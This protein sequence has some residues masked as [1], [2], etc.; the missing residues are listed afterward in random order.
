MR[1]AATLPP[2][3]GSFHRSALEREARGLSRRMSLTRAARMCGVSPGTVSAWAD[4]R[5][6]TDRMAA[7]VAIAAVAAA[8]GWV[9][10]FG[11]VRVPDGLRIEATDSCGRVL[12]RVIPTNDE[13]GEA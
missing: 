13:R 4:G 9:G 8:N 2:M 3:Q 10:T 6:L 12:V 1:T 11:T 5:P 7:R